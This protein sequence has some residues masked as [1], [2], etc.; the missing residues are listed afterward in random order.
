MVVILLTS[1]LKDV[2]RG[3]FIPLIFHRSAGVQ[4]AKPRISRV[5]TRKLAVACTF[6]RLNPRTPRRLPLRNTL[7]CA[8]LLFASGFADGPQLLKV[9]RRPKKQ[10]EA[11]LFGVGW[12]C[13][14]LI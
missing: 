3:V 9:V 14:V 7:A 4:E 12:I 5:S 6:S 1:L 2:S 13:L 10:S 11:A 8:F